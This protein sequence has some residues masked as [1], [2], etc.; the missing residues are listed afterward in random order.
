[1]KKA[2]LYILAISAI[3]ISA[4]LIVTNAQIIMRVVISSS[5]ADSNI[6]IFEIRQSGM[7]RLRYGYP[8]PEKIDNGK[9]LILKERKAFWQKRIPKDDFDE[10][11]K[12]VSDISIPSKD[13]IMGGRDVTIMYGDIILEDINE[14]DSNPAFQSFYDK[15][16][17][18]FSY[19]ME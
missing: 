3:F 13:Q 6:Y 12:L 19:M 4:L 1:M 15:L 16:R 18:I 9:T 7:A 14:N 5:E 10:L 8:F 2:S 17:E 11:L